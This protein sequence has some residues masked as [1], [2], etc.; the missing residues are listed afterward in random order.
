MAKP[1]R[2]HRS[3]P[4]GSLHVHFPM[5]TS[6]LANKFKAVISSRLLSDQTHPE[7]R[8]ASGGVVAGGSTDPNHVPGLQGRPNAGKSQRSRPIHPQTLQEKHRNSPNM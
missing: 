6:R 5:P 7:A 4:V 1:E 8:D 2:P 3:Y